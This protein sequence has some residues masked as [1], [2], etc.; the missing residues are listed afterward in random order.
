[1]ADPFA[2]RPFFGY[3]FGHYL[4][5]WLNVPRLHPSPKLPKI[6]HVNWFRKDAETSSFLWPGFGENSRVLDWIIRRIETDENP[7]PVYRTPIGLLPQK[8]TFRL[9]GLKERV[10]W[11]QLFSVPRDFWKEECVSLEKYF[12]EQVGRDLPTEITNQLSLLKRRLDE[13]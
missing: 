5:H 8:D 1:M 10:D 2:M 9:D 12:T 13:P 4:K 11:D 3:N 6:F 7:P